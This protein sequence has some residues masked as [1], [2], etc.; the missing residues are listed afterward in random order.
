MPYIKNINGE[1]EWVDGFVST[2]LMPNG[3]KYGLQANLIEVKE[4]KCKNCGHPLQL[5]Y[6][7]GTCQMCGSHYTTQFEIA[8]T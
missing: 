2:I 8:E 1:T 3:K 6:G 4:I 5:R 7:E